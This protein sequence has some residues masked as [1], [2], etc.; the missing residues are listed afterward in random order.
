MVKRMEP[1]TLNCQ[2]VGSPTPEITWYKDGEPLEMDYSHKMM[3][4]GG[5][6]FF[7]KVVHSKRESDAGVYWCEAKNDFGIARSH[8]ATLTV[9]VL[10]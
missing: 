3:L 8:N 10:I 4:P 2:T 7:L 6:L 5:E 9:A 1:T